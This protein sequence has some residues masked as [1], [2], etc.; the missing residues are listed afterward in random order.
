MKEFN[1]SMTILK[2]HLD[3]YGH[4]NNAIYMQLY[5]NARWDLLSEI[6][7]KRED[8]TEQKKGPIILEAAL[9]FKRELIEGELITIKS[10]FLELL[11]SKVAVLN[12]V[13]LKEDGSISGQAEFKIG[14][15]DLLERKLIN[16]PNKWLE[17]I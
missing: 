2:E 13:I 8:V 4:V 17:Y 14:Y 12:Q 7:F 10:N 5:E 1:Y 15:M 9:K 6:G 16:V 3:L 11:K